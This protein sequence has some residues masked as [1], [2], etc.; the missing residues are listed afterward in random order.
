MKGRWFKI[1]KKVG[2]YIII[3]IFWIA[4]AFTFLSGLIGTFIK[5]ADDPQDDYEEYVHSNVP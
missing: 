5:S 2:T 1:L 3:G 4:I